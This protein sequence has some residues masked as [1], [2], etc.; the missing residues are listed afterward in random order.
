MKA[1]I[2]TND[3]VSQTQLAMVQSM[4]GCESVEVRPTKDLLLTEARY[5]GS[6]YSASGELQSID[7]YTVSLQINVGE[8]MDG[9]KQSARGHVQIDKALV[10]SELKDY[11]HYLEGLNVASRL[12]NPRHVF[13]KTSDQR[14]VCEDPNRKWY[15]L[16]FADGAVVLVIEDPEEIEINGMVRVRNKVSS[17]IV[18]LAPTKCQKTT[19]EREVF[20]ATTI[21][22]EDWVSAASQNAVGTSDLLMAAADVSFDEF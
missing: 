13:T 21:K 19:S 17:M 16:F 6:T 3:N 2:V 9:T 11:A 15:S 22:S 14:L 5:V 8:N 10:P 12:I 4:T 20:T 1:I 7:G 18:A